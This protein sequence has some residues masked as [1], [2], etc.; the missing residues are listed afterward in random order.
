MQMMMRRVKKL[1]ELRMKVMELKGGKGN[2][3][4]R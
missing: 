1:I 3:D 2:E 4:H